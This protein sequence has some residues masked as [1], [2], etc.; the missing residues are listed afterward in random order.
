MANF[1]KGKIAKFK[2][3]IAISGQILAGWPFGPSFPF[4]LAFWAF[5]SFHFGI[6]SLH[7]L[8][9]WPFGPSFPFILAFWAFISFHFGLFFW[10]FISFHFGLLGL[11]FLS[12]WSFG[13]HFLSLAF[14]ATYLAL[15][16][17]NFGK[18]KIA[19]FKEQNALWG[20]ILAGWP[21][22]FH[23]LSLW[24]FGHSFPFHF[25][26]LG[27]HFLSFWFLGAITR[28]GAPPII[29]HFT[30]YCAC[31]EKGHFDFTKYSPATQN[32][33]HHWCASQMKR[34]SQSAQ[35]QVS[36]CNIT[37]YCACHANCVSW[38]DSSLTLLWLHSIT[39]LF[40]D[41]LV[42]D[43]SM[44][45]LI[46]LCL[47]WVRSISWLF[48]ELPDSSMT[49]FMTWLLSDLTLLLLDSITGPFYELTLRSCSYIGS[50][51]TKLPLINILG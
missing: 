35:H 39:W 14:W 42:L 32:D 1:G 31:H 15:Q 29:P 13:L 5:I 41:L 48:Y 47:F 43:S 21:L 33:S 11:H 4:I 36:S 44:T 17:A 3:K 28:F 18:G 30:E 22:G 40:Y 10:A 46:L 38:V 20:Q 2:G 9:F 45:C 26:L 25:G 49:C 6:L 16:V 8:S 27:F 37:K 51:I 7:F 24:P 50:W 23:F 34:Y 19:K 12:F